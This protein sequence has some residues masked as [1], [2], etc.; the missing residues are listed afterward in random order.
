MAF[1]LRLPE[2]RPEFEF[3]GD[4]MNREYAPCSGRVVAIGRAERTITTPSRRCRSRLA[5]FGVILWA[6]MLAHATVRADAASDLEQAVVAIEHASHANDGIRVVVGHLSR[7]LGIPV[8]TLRAQRS[9]T[10]LRWGELMIAHRLSKEAQLDLARV[11]A[12]FQSGKRWAD[13]ARDSNVDVNTV[14]DDVR[15]SQAVVEQRLEDR[16]PRAHSA[17]PPDTSSAPARLPAG[18]PVGTTPGHGGH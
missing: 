18:R 6:T 7:T 2:G 11:I 12:E 15:R 14:L 1:T 4:P 3:M 16:S 5:A 10:G 13:I 8:E 9:T 17:G